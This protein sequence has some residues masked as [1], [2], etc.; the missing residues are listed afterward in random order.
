[1]TQWSAWGERVDHI[2]LMRVWETVAPLAAKFGLVARAYEQ[3]GASARI[4]QLALLYL[5]TPASDRY[6]CP[7]ARLNGAARTLLTA[8]HEAL[9]ERAVPRLTSR[10]PSIAWTSGQWMTPLIGG[11]DVSNTETI[12]RLGQGRWRLYGKTWGT[13]AITADMALTLARPESSPA[14]AK[15]L[16]L[17]YDETRDAHG[18][19]NGM[20][21]ERLK[22]KLGTRKLAT[23]EL[24]LDGTLATPVSGLTDGTRNI[25]PMLAV[26]R[27]WNSVSAVAFRAA[28]RTCAMAMDV[29]ERSFR[30]GRR[31]L[32]QSQCQ[33]LGRLRPG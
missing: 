17:F 16:A 6:S 19:L 4:Q 23:A 5:F 27:T 12:A 25:E 13:S 33:F 20:R 3:P 21:V 28:R 8:G 18:R 24:Q 11:F 1:L 14:G 15:G 10:D 22:D 32:L 2:E 7:L 31:T 9:I 30:D 26:T 29:R